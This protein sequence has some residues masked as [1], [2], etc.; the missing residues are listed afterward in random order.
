MMI[1]EAVESS[2]DILL[3]VFETE[4]TEILGVAA[5]AIGEVGFEEA[6]PYLEG[7]E[8]REE[9]V[10]I[11]INSDFY[12]KTIGQWAQEAMVKLEAN[13]SNTENV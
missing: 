11:Y 5:W 6:L 2:R 9:K 10:R 1:R 8:N 7:L 4:E 3:G 12:Q 13:P